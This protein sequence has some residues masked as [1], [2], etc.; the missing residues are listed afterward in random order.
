MG[1][2][3]AWLRGSWEI[4]R[5]RFE[6]FSSTSLFRIRL[7]H[8]CL[9]CY[10]P[11]SFL[12]RLVLTRNIEMLSLVIYMCSTCC[13]TVWSYIWD[14]LYGLTSQCL[15]SF[16]GF[17]SVRLCSSSPPLLPE[18]NEDLCRLVW[19]LEPLETFWLRDGTMNAKRKLNPPDA[20]HPI[21]LFGRISSKNEIDLVH[22]S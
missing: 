5:Q 13:A 18:M 17:P 4:D 1:L 10:A 20:R 21:I 22:A 9:L 7:H 6:Q 16:A 2:V 11:T 3:R 15:P 14:L 19:H 12:P 8:I